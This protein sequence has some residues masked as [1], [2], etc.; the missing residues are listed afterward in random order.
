L[1]GHIGLRRRY[2]IFLSF[3]LSLPILATLVVFLWMHHVWWWVAKR[4]EL[5]YTRSTFVIDT[6]SASLPS[7]YSIARFAARHVPD[8]WKVFFLLVPN[9][10]IFAPIVVT[11]LAHDAAPWDVVGLDETTIMPSK[12]SIVV[13]RKSITVYFL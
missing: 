13:R 12:A 3:F 1:V 5:L 11:C 9:G 7:T 2:Y 10:I 6:M 4:K 8:R